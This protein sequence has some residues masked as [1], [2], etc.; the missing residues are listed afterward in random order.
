M[1]VIRTFD[2]STKIEGNAAKNR[3]F[4][5]LYLV[6]NTEF[7]SICLMFNEEKEEKTPSSRLHHGQTQTFGGARV[8]TVFADGNLLNFYSALLVVV[9]EYTLSETI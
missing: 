3:D 1:S 9:R 5:V 7:H 4:S 2:C 6:A 8:R